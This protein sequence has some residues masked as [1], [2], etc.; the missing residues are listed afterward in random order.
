MKEYLVKLM[1]LGPYFFG[2]EKIFD[3]SN[4]KSSRYYIKGE[5]MP[6]QS[7][8][9]GVLRYLLMPIKKSDW[10]YHENDLKANQKV[11]GENGFNPENADAD[12]GK[13]HKLSPVFLLNATGPLVRT[14]FDHIEDN[15][16][17]TPFSNYRTTVIPG[18]NFPKEKYYAMEYD[19]KAGISES[20]M[21]LSDG[22]IIPF[23]KI[24]KSDTRVG[25]NR[26]EKEGGFFKKEYKILLDGICFAVYAELADDI[27]PSDGIVY[28]GQGKSAFSVSFTEQK[29]KLV[30]DIQKY[31]REDVVYVAGDTF[32]SASIYDDVFFAVT[33]TKTYRHFYKYKN[34]VSKGDKLYNIIQAGSILIPYNKKDFLKKLENTALKKAGHNSFVYKEEN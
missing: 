27:V 10:N 24:F 7:A 31:L 16:T 4:N 22:K 15:N 20:F 30:S 13:I 19:A 6:S 25:I 14:P 34:K 3:Y 29:N 21:Q 8:V 5:N 23:S 32:A 11:I 18:E 12:Y 33:K 28:M 26:F 2:N 9:L 1:P 17:Y